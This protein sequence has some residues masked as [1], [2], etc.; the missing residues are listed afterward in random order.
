MKILETKRSSNISN[1]KWKENK[2]IISFLHGGIYEYYDVALSVF[3]QFV[4]AEN[5][6]ESIGSLFNEIVKKQGYRYKKIS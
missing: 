3:E 6:M 5:N 2:L 1:I 4:T